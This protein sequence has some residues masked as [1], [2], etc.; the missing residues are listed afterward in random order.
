M[1]GT[2]IKVTVDSSRLQTALQT[3]A[4]T[5][6][7]L[8]QACLKNIGGL[9]V[10]QTRARFE[11]E[12]GPDGRKWP[13]LNTEY[14][15]GKKQGSKILTASGQLRMSIVWQLRGNT[16]EVGTNK[17]YGAIHQFGGKIVP[18]SA[19]ALRFKLD[20]R[21]VTAKSVKIPARP[22]LGVSPANERPILDVIADHIDRVWERD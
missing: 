5:D 20:G 11:T 4:D 6:G 15:K 13:A 12:T 7:S 2:Q 1:A 10:K 22:F 8:M 17:V 9:V 14:A 19:S 18:R 21:W 3:L 16:L